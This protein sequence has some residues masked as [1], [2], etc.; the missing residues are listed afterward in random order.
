MYFVYCLYSAGFGKTYVGRTS[1]LQ[2]RLEAHNHPSNKGYTKRYQPWGILFFEE[3]KTVE[4]ASQRERFY[5]SGMG[6]ELI[7]EQLA[8]I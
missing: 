4:E 3:F 7:K 2:G 6:R 1:N 8:K 5:K